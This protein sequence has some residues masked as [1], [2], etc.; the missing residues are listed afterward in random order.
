QQEQF[1]GV[2]LQVMQMDGDIPAVLENL[3]DGITYYQGQLDYHLNVAFDGRKPVG[4]N[5]YD[6][7]DTQYGNGDPKNRDKDES[8][9]THV[10]G[11]IAASRGN[12]KGVDGVAKNVAIM[13][14][15]TVPDGDEYDKDVALAIRYA[16]DNGAKVI[17]ASFGKDFSPNA[18]WV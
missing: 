8:H 9:G 15:R 11:I 4:D 6:I 10:A 13:S 7:T 5:P 17:N 12:E 16:V 2:L 1:V 18:E 3:A 14:I